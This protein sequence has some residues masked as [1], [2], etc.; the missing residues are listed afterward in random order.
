MIRRPPRSTRTDTLFPYTTLFRSDLDGTSRALDTLLDCVERANAL[1]S[2]GNPFA[3]ARSTSANPFAGND[4]RAGSN[5]QDIVEGLLLASGLQDIVFVDPATTGFGDAL[6]TWQ[7][8]E[9][10]GAVYVIDSEGRDLEA[11]VGVVLGTLAQECQGGFASK[12]RPVERVRRAQVKQF[13]AACRAPQYD[14]DYFYA[15]PAVSNGE[16]VMM[17]YNSS[18]LGA[19]DLEKVNLA[20]LDALPILLPE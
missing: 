13:T 7:A 4:S 16:K 5:D 2:P 8:G 14:G 6:H 15:F 12:P 19:A 18:E 3:D 10:T 11:M 20:I 17:L 9:L 1:S